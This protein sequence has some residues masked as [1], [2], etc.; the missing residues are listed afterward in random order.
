M[1]SGQVLRLSFYSKVRFIFGGNRAPGASLVNL[2]II[3]GGCALGA[4]L[5]FF[6]LSWIR[7]LS[8]S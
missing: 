2:G 6:R 7:A 1:K 5:G 4:I 8:L 3:L